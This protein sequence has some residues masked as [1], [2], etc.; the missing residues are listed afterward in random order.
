MAVTP[1]EDVTSD[2]LDMRRL[3]SP[4]GADRFFA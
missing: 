2:S 3:L 4:I 1:T